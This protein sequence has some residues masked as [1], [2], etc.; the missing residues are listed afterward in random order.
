MAAIRIKGNCRTCPYAE[1]RDEMRVFCSFCMRKVLKT[2]DG[3]EAGMA[4]TAGQAG[5]AAGMEA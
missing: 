1:Y 5:S 2:G 3:R 4:S